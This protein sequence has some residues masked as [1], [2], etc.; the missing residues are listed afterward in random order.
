MGSIRKAIQALCGH[1][2][3]AELPGHYV[4]TVYTQSY[5]EHYVDM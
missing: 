1:G 3:Y 4:D 2:L 5:Q